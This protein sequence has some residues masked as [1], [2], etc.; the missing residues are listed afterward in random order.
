MS[1]KESIINVFKDAGQPLRTGEVVKQ[2]GL[3]KKDVEKAIKE[4]KDEGTIYSPKRCYL[5]LKQ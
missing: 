3:E 2:T 5:D 4:M 1:I